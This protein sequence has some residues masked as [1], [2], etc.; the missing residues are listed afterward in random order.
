MRTPR[1]FSGMPWLLRQVLLACAVAGLVVAGQVVGARTSAAA[2]LWG[3]DGTVTAVVRSGNT[4]F[5]GGAFNHVGPC[6][7]SGVPLN[8][9]SGAVPRRY[10]KV[11]GTVYAASSDGAGGWYIGGEFSAVGG[12]ARH[13]LAHVLADGTVASWAPNP[14]GVVW[15]LAV[16]GGVVYVGGGFGTIGNR[17]RNLIAAVDG[18]TGRATDWDPQADTADPGNY[19]LFVR[20]IAIHGHTVY[21]GGRFTHLG[22]EQRSNLAALDLRTARPTPWNPTV[23]GIVHAIAADERYVYIGGHVWSVGG[24]LRNGLAA[25]DARSGALASWDLHP[26]RPNFPWYQPPI[27]SALALRGG[28]LYAAG[29]FEKIGGQVRHGLAA[30]DALT[31]ALLPWA[32]DPAGGSPYTYLNT[33]LVVGSS[34]YIGGNFKSAGGAE[35]NCLAEVDARTGLAT[36][37]NPRPNS[38][39][40]ALAADDESIYAGGYFTFLGTW[41]RRPCLAALDATTGELKSWDAHLAGYQVH[42]LTVRGSTLYVGGDFSE[43]GGLGRSYLAAFDV[44]TA[45]P[46]PWIPRPGGPVWCLASSDSLL[47]V[48]GL[49][50][51]MGGQLRRR[52]AAIRLSDGT[53]TAWDPNADDAVTTLVVGPDAIYAGGLFGRIGGQVRSRIAALDPA[54]GSATSWDAAV[55]SWGWVNSLAVA[56]GTVYIGGLFIGVAGQLRNNLAAVDASTGAA[57][58]WNPD[59]D[60]EVEAVCVSGDKVYAGGFFRSVSGQSRRGLVALDATSA[61]VAEWDPIPDAVIW[62]LFA[63]SGTLYAG[64][65]F[66][67]V[68]Y[69]PQ[70]NVA[71]IPMPRA[72]IEDVWPVPKPLISASIEPNPARMNAVIR[73]VTSLPGQVKLVF[74]DL[75]G[76][77]IASIFDSNDVV[78][79]PREIHVRTAEWPAGTY[80]C[81]LEGPNS[82]VTRKLIVLK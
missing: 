28:V 64:G 37:W 62:A 72:D 17:R 23:G 70:I 46:V 56:R 55:H 38:E 14:N 60:G 24:Q 47:Y 78:A 69:L 80:F 2:E 66:G 6:M 77:Q 29:C 79:G 19:G 39:V 44:E 68:G 49:F 53:P 76:R 82:A 32:P 73:F 48:G 36:S 20:S 11:I 35:R 63:D 33:L 7:G 50:G 71:A 26:A 57:T 74:Y 52:I 67:S 61:A 41:Q 59:A 9:R 18:R 13:N 45:N 25:V 51:S 10:A 5:V 12:E 75:Q 54:T 16:K 42:A 15:A 1:C 40:W 22:A 81:R 8:I 4:I 21:I 31:G 30:I 3:T 58:A 65:N 27:V 34:V 43:V